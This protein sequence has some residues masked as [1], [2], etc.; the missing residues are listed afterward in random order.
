[1]K[2]VQQILA[3]IAR[4]HFSIPTLEPRR[5]DSLDFHDI[6]VWQVEAALKVAFEA[7]VQSARTYPE[8]QGAP[9][10]I[11]VPAASLATPLLVPTGTPLVPRKMYLRLYHGRTDP[12]QEMDGWG[13]E[14]PTFGPLSCY[15]HTYCTTFRIHGDCSTSEV[16]L[17]RYDDMIRWDGCFY[18]DMEVFLAGANN[19][20]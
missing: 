9:R 1:M 3:D 8:S 14:G 7:G 4:E 11:L 12:A 19:R 5:A 16:W 20:A 15:V 6:A 2:P 18:G 13:A 17:E 10:G